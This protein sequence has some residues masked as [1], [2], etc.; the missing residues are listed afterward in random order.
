MPALCK[1]P[2]A[3]QAANQQPHSYASSQ[4]P[5]VNPPDPVEGDK[6]ILVCL[7][8]TP[9]AGRL[10]R[11]RQAT[12]QCSK[13]ADAFAPSIRR[14]TASIT[15]QW[16]EPSRPWKPSQYGRCSSQG[17]KEIS[18]WASRRLKNPC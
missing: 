1:G 16:A 17:T 5:H 9:K 12:S 3:S 8:S 11:F 6:K 15:R 14:L 7:C 13:N 2:G 18:R 10:A 4:Q